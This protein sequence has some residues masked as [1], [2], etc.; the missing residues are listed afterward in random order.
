MAHTRAR[1]GPELRPPAPAWGSRSTV[2]CPCCG[3]CGRTCLCL[4]V[5]TFVCSVTGTSL[6]PFG[7]SP[8]WVWVTDEP[9]GRRRGRT[10]QGG[11]GCDGD[12]AVSRAA[13]TSCDS[14]GP[15][16]SG[17]RAPSL[18]SSGRRGPSGCPFGEMR[19]RHLDRL[20]KQPCGF[21]AWA[22]VG[23]CCFS[24]LYG[25]LGTHPLLYPRDPPPVVEGGTGALRM[26]EWALGGEWAPGRGTP[27]SC[28]TCPGKC[29]FLW[30]LWGWH[31]QQLPTLFSGRFLLGKLPPVSILGPQW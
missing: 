16:S 11:Q 31:H 21:P 27:S 17:P 28:R 10:A 30:G 20:G 8:C 6:G 9:L 4:S 13:P 18:G 2:G 1:A 3:V 5:Q 24:L 14:T 29:P 22:W 12:V 25:S 15:T 26:G 19:I 23:G 7:A